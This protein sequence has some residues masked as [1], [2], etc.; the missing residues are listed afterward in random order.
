M[1]R[2]MT[3]KKRYG[4]RL[5]SAT[6]I[7]LALGL[8]FGLFTGSLVLYVGAGLLLGLVVDWNRKQGR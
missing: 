7:G 4:R 1:G 5:G 6:F 8:S 3:E 2:T